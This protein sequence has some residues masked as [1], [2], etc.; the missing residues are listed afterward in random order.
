[1][2]PTEKFLFFLCISAGYFSFLSSY[3]QLY[4]PDGLV[5]S[6]EVSSINDFR[7]VNKKHVMS[8]ESISSECA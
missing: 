7:N 6:F 2:N 1:M 8:S 3:L 5:I 4:A